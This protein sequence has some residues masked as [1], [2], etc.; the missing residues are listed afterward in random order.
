MINKSREYEH[1]EQL[2]LIA[3]DHREAIKKAQMKAKANVKVV[4]EQG[5]LRLERSRRANKVLRGKLK[6]RYLLLF[7][8]LTIGMDCITH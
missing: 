7:S 5:D 4:V 6:V 1:N 8:H 3:R 2:T